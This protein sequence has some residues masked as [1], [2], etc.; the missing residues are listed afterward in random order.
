[1]GVF[2]PLKKI[3][4]PVAAILLTLTACSAA[5]PP[6]APQPYRHV[7]PSHPRNDHSAKP[8]RRGTPDDSA[9]TNATDDTS[10]D[11]T[12]HQYTTT[13]DRFISTHDSY[14]AA[15]EL[16]ISKENIDKRR[17]QMDKPKN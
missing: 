14:T 6:P 12:D 17:H 15:Y 3:I 4:I 2:T 11:A 10:G 5:T 9:P 1:M 13:E 7:V 16:G 8:Q